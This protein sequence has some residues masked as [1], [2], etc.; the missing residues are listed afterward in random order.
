MIHLA[1][2]PYLE[3][4]L[5]YGDENDEQLTKLQDLSDKMLTRS[6]LLQLLGATLEAMCDYLRTDLAFVVSINGDAD[7]VQST[8]A[9]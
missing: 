3:E 7:L 5:I 1:L 8:P 2:P 4:W 6:D 9:Q